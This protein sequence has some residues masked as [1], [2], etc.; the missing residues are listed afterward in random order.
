M[1]EESLPVRPVIYQLFVRLF[2]NT[3]ETRKPHGSI[4]ENGCG[5]FADIN[6]AALSSLKEMGFTHVWLTGILEQASGT[7]Y[8][9][10][11]GDDPDILKGMA[12]SPYAI[13]DYFDVCPDYAVDPSRRLEEFKELVDRCH[14][15]GLKVIIDFVPNHV[16]RSYIS[17]VRPD[18]TFGH[19]DN[20]DVF[21][22][23]DNHYYYLP[24]DEVG[25][26]L[27]LPKFADGF[28][29]PEAEYGKVT[30]N[31]VISWHP[32]I[33]DW[34]ETVKLNYGHDFTKGRDTSHLPGADAAVSEVPKTGQT[35]D[36][37][38]AYWQETGVDGFRAD[39]AHMIPMEFWRWAV[40]RARARQAHVFFSA[41]AYNND[42]AKLTEGHA[43]D[44]LLE[45]GFDAVYDKQSYDILE[46]IYEK[47]KWA[48]DLDS[49]NFDGMR[50]HRSLRFAENHDEVRLACPEVWGGHGMEVGRPVSGVL[51][52][53]G[54]GA[55]M[56]Y[57]GQ[58]VGEAG[59]DEAGFSSDHKRTTIFDYWSMKEFVKWTNGGKYDGA[60]L[61]DPQKG[62]RTWYSKLLKVL[63]HRA[64]TNGDFF[65]LN[66][67]NR[68]N[69]NFGRVDGEEVSGHWVY[70][71][72]RHDRKSGE[73]Y[74]VV[75]NFHP[76][77]VL[78]DVA[79]RI[80]E[81]AWD[82]TGR[83]DDEKWVFEDALEGNWRGVAE[84]DQLKDAG[85]AV[86]TLEP[87]SVAFLEISR[88]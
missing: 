1:L 81:G 32:S 55:I 34:Y 53:L 29:G 80:P 58:E 71:F 21:F 86:G 85:I 60:L 37:I 35:M 63:S 76:T 48:N 67:F 46:G 88:W 4:E 28:Y 33:D 12:G 84:R 31:N 40:K 45:S 3:N 82:F 77:D 24:P 66:Y 36:R 42:P 8:P 56:I 74:L 23:R 43:L 69:E 11:P 75:A 17:D 79:V 20:R 61:S 2:G 26:P 10:R 73:S 64:F 54:R 16:A 18:D 59:G 14:D 47:G 5:K 19:G 52:G 44:A 72:L 6:G 70:A 15:Y 13:R 38:L 22:D 87:L 39:M 27:K 83:R 7:D 41:E 25:P 65:G 51:F 62:L 50:F 30:G 68:E 49:H 78:T 57:S 9:G